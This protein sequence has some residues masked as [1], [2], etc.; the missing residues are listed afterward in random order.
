MTSTIISRKDLIYDVYEYLLSIGLFKNQDALGTS[1]EMP[2]GRLM[3][4]SQMTTRNK[5]TVANPSPRSLSRK[6][7]PKKLTSI[8]NMKSHLIRRGTTI[9][10]MNGPTVRDTNFKQSFRIGRSKLFK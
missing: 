7:R 5:S 1:D 6:N 10:N 4:V 3:N 8:V 9:D 2:T